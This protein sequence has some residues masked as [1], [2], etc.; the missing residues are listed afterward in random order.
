MLKSFFTCVL[1]LNCFTVAPLYAQDSCAK[2]FSPFP[3]FSGLPVFIVPPSA[4]HERGM[5]GTSIINPA[6]VSWS[7]KGS[8]KITSQK[9]EEFSLT[10]Q[11]SNRSLKAEVDQPPEKFLVDFDTLDRETPLKDHFTFSSF[12]LTTSIFFKIFSLEPAKLRLEFYQGAK[13]YALESRHYGEGL[14]TFVFKT[15]DL[16]IS[17]IRNSQNHRGIN[18]SA[19]GSH[20]ISVVG[21]IVFERDP[22]DERVFKDLLARISK[23]S[24]KDS[25]RILKT[26]IKNLFDP[27]AAAYAL[28][29]ANNPKLKNIFL[30][31]NDLTLF[32]LEQKVSA[33]GF[34]GRHKK[35]PDWPLVPIEVEPFAKEHGADSHLLQLIAATYD[36]DVRVRKKIVHLFNFVFQANDANIWRLWDIIFDGPG[37]RLPSTPRY[38]RDRQAVH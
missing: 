21:P 23:H 36:V 7:S 34:F 31:E 37:N 14:Q 33:D 18:I 27:K 11:G 10:L 3:S 28:S 17:T 15:D 24:L 22:R 8:T 20:Q 5:S 1:V 38:W 25:E 6:L 12:G 16:K 2:L 29:V 13:K 32:E 35:M 4:P 19:Q 9:T 26:I 30:N